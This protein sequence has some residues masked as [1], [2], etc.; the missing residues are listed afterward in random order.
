MT[1]RPHRRAIAACSLTLVA[2][3]A[4]SG[5]GDPD[6]T[7]SAS[8]TS[9]ERGVADVVAPATPDLATPDT[10]ETVTG[11]AFAIREAAASSAQQPSMQ[12]QMQVTIDGQPVTSSTMRTTADGMTAWGSTTVPGIG[13]VPM[14]VTGGAYYYGFPNLP[15]GKQWVRL[16]FDE[17]SDAVG[18][19]PNAM[20]Q[21]DP[22]QAFAMLDAISDEVVTVG[23]EDVAGVSTTHYRF[24][25]RVD[26]MYDRLVDQGVLTPEAAGAITQLNESADFEVWIGSD[27]LVHRL[28]Y[29]LQVD[30][31]MG[32]PSTVDYEFEYSEYGGPVDVTAPV[33]EATMSMSDMMVQRD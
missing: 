33:P 30:T 8:L 14:L 21:Q 1:V 6:R 10:P 4:L 16:S 12:M 13:E 25:V 27:G 31:G 29:S 26:D 19:D 24:A 2:L 15:D 9:S 5:C 3:L 23:E 7:A 22:T 32:A 20:T 18:I 11:A 17:L 28:T